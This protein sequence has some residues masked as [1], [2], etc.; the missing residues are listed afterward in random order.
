MDESPREQLG[1]FIGMMTTCF[2]AMIAAGFMP[3]WNVLP[4]LGWLA[5]ATIGAAIGGVIATPRA[6]RGAICG[7][8]MGAGALYGVSY[9]VTARGW[10]IDFNTFSNLELVLGAGLGA[11]PGFALYCGWA[12]EV[13]E[14][15][16]DETQ[17][18]DDAPQ[19]D[20]PQKEH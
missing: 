4:F 8:L 5:I 9:Y 3:D 11:I 1:G 20:S 14:E 13:E 2:P 6:V 7:A 12:R 17:S 16:E 10:L 15:Q 19:E 18:P